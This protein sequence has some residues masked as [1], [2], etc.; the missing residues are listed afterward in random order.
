MT[1]LNQPAL[2]VE[3]AELTLPERE[4]PAGSER[5]RRRSRRV[6][7]E[8][9][10]WPT[11]TILVLCA[12]TVLLPLYV[13]VSMALKSG[14]QVVDGNAFSFP[15]PIS[16]DGFV[17]AWTLTEFPVGLA[18]S[19]LVTAGTVVATII[20]A[21]FASYAIARNWDRKLFRYSFFYLLAA[22]FIPFPVVACRRSSSRVASG[23][24]TRWA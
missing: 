1:A 21:A 17:Q 19:L 20:L 15:S 10:N 22:M 7:M 9:V 12:L 24:T 11:T 8:R 6:G 23:S 16:L 2:A 13:T 18:I 4:G 3:Q 5:S 14:T